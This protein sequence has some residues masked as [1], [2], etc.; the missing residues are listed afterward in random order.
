[1]RRVT[2]TLRRMLNQDI[3]RANAAGASAAL[4][5]RRAEHD[6]VDAYLAALAW[7]DGHPPQVVARSV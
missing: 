6:D 1:M 3:A 2:G 7:D 5:E 4:R